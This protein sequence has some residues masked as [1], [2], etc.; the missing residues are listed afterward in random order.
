MTREE[1]AIRAYKICAMALVLSD[2][3]HP[4]K[5]IVTRDLWDKAMKAIDEFDEVLGDDA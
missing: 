2:S 4:N 1:Q 3:S 5:V